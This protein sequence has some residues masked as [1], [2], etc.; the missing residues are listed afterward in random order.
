L[1][2]WKNPSAQAPEAGFLLPLIAPLAGALIE[3]GI[4]FSAEWLKRFQGELSA[5]S[6]AHDVSAHDVSTMYMTLGGKLSA[7]NACLVFL[8]G[9]LGSQA[10]FDGRLQAKKIG[11]DP[12]WTSARLQILRNGWQNE[13]V[14][15][16]G[17][18]RRGR[19]PVV[20]TPLVYAE[21]EIRYN[22][23]RQATQ[24]MIKPIFLDYRATAAE[25]KGA[26]K[27]DIAFIVSFERNDNRNSP[28]TFAKYNIVIPKTSIGAMYNSE[29]LSDLVG[30][31][32]NLPSP[33]SG[34]DIFDPVPISVM[35]SMVETEKAGDLE[36]LFVETID[37]NKDRLGAAISSRI[38][39]WLSSKTEER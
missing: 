28:A 3:K 32:Q 9:E 15:E 27:K 39:Q 11:I 38:E 5:S 35:V 21:F 20:G 17:D 19:I 26:G 18:T 31:P 4:S 14:A 7:R 22:D 8:R 30:I 25:R 34:K 37:D 29:T 12:N 36:R 33:S 6:S 1:S 23:A 24:F 2:N 16:G 10:E 13:Q